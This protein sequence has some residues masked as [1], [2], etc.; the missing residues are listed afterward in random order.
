MSDSAPER[1]LVSGPLARF[2]DGFREHLAE[3]GY[4]LRTKRELLQLLAHLSRWMEVQELEVGALTSAVSERFILERRAQGYRSSI[5]LRSPSRVLGYLE[6]VGALPVD[7]PV[8]SPLDEL[9]GAYARYL[10]EERGLDERTVAGYVG[11][12]R[13]FL[14]ERPESIED[15]LAG[16]SG[17][18]IN[19]FV[20]REFRRH[21]QRS[22]ERVVYALRAL[23]RYLHVQGLIERPLAGGVLS[24][25]RRREDLPRGL[26]GEQVRLLLDSCDRSTQIGCRDHAILLLLARLGLRCSEIA[27]LTLDDIDWRA[28]EV[29]IRGKGSRIDRLPLPADVGEALADYLCRGRPRGFGRVLFLNG[30]A[31]VAA[32]SR[33]TV[34][35]VV[36]RACRRV[37]MPP[38]RGHCLR[39]TVA[40]ELLR[41]GA[42]LAEIGQ[43]LRHQ[44]QRT[45]SIYAKVDRAALSRLALPWPGSER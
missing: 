39:H 32:L 40:T 10:R 13:Q 23:L 1:V 4:T 29:V 5:S 11:I 36:V 38:V 27:A 37:G 35:M 18:E 34:S 9:L 45:T 28:G 8:L 31:P 19:A 14:A 16:L 26:P 30:R 24:V 7:E 33:D 41:R 12:A 15:R 43:V 6:S 42:G 22:A 3:K 21:S 2:A 25:A 17:G 20:L 44:D